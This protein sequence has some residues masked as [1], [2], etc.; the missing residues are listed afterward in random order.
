VV[1]VIASPRNIHRSSIDQGTEN[2]DP[3]IKL[4]LTALPC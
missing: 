2:R 3:P 1:S 4:Q